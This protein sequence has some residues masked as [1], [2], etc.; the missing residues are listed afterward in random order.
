MKAVDHEGS[1]HSISKRSP[2]WSVPAPF[3]DCRP[4]AK[5]LQRLMNSPSLSQDL[6]T[7]AGRPQRLFRGS[8]S[9]EESMFR[10]HPNSRRRDLPH[11]PVKHRNENHLDVQRLTTEGSTA[12]NLSSKSPPYLTVSRRSLMPIFNASEPR[13]LVGQG[14]PDDP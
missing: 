9:Y 10:H 2:N 11:S 8:P 13:N 12:R 6:R 4:T 7:T 1:M 5:D 14:T 3:Q